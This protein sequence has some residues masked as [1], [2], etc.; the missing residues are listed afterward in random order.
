MRVLS[1]PVDF[2]TIDRAG[3]YERWS[4]GIIRTL[5]EN[6][7]RDRVRL[8]RLPADFDG[9]PIYMSSA[10]GLKAIL[11][12]VRKVDPVLLQTAGRIVRDSDVVWDIGGN[13]GLFAVAASVKAGGSGKVFV[14]EPDVSL[15]PLIRKNAR[16]VADRY[17]PIDIVPAAV[18]GKTELR[19]F[20]VAARARASNALVGYGN[21]QMG[22]VS[23][24]V[25]VVAL[26]IDDCLSWLPDPD[27]VKID[28]EGAELEI[29][30]SAGALLETVRP[31]LACEINGDSAD[32]IGEILSRTE[33]A[34]FDPASPI[35]PSA[36]MGS[37]KFNTIAI[38][39]EKVESYVRNRSG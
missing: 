23:E 19:K 3:F 17:A 7:L 24:T 39:R 20:A 37:S 33:Y 26:S 18:A 28:V 22:G 16:L 2:P 25:T 11:K 32:G 29:L 6:I 38:P 35:E 14:F 5:A 13:I 21:S 10:G 8:R 4:M 30:S 1:W 36:E 31:A 27:V 9:V 12:P 15:V 34:M